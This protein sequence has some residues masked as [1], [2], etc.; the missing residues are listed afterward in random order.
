MITDN[1]DT[2]RAWIEQAE[3]VLEPSPLLM[4]VSAQA[5][6]MIR[7][8]YDSGQVQGMVTGLAGGAAYE[9]K[10]GRSGLAS[11]YWDAFSLSLLVATILILIGG[12]VNASL[13][14]LA[15]NKRK[16]EEQPYA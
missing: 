3:P 6:P 14:S 10:R 4:V 13:S 15:R 8:Y 5:E 16:G 1:P 12:L 7:P 9:N 11:E 2:A